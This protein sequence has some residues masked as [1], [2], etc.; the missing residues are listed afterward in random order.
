MLRYANDWSIVQEHMS[1]PPVGTLEQLF[2]A[3]ATLRQ[4]RAP[5]PRYEVSRHEQGA[6]FIRDART[7]N[8]IIEV[9]GLGYHGSM[10]EAE[11][12]A[13]ILNAAEAKK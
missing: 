2:Y 10:Q 5:K 12:I 9:N 3:V 6:P 1:T 13:A 4:S 11:R 7:S 8:I